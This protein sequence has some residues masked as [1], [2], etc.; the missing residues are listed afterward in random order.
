MLFAKYYSGD[1]IH[2]H[3][4]GRECSRDGGRGEIHAVCVCVCVCVC[5]EQGN[6][7]KWD[8]LWRPRDS[9]DDNIKI[10]IK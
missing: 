7:K 5:V 3:E 10:D 1:E 2:E 8:E 9:R 4:V 6:L